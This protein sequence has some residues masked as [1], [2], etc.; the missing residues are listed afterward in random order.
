LERAYVG[1][2]HPNN[3]SENLDAHGL[4]C[5]NH[6][7]FHRKSGTA[8]AGKQEEVAKLEQGMNWLK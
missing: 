7:V 6:V 5:S 3:T 8:E 2:H 1:L 4:L